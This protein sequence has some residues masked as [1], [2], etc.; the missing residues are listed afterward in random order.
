LD[1][2]P[3]P[4]V[5]G[6]ESGTVLTGGFNQILGYSGPSDP[7]AAL[8]YE[9]DFVTFLLVEGFT[10]A[11]AELQPDPKISG[12]DIDTNNDGVVDVTPWTAVLDGIGYTE[13]D[14]IGLGHLY[15]DQLGG[16][17]IG[18]EAAHGVGF[19]AD[20]VGRDPR[21]PEDWLMYDTSDGELDPGYV[22]LFYAN[23]GAGPGDSDAAHFDTSAGIAIE[24]PVYPTSTFLFATPGA[25]N[26]VPE[27]SSIVALIAAALSGCFAFGRRRCRK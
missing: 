16:L 4:G 22:G 1:N 7:P 8:E 27:P 23:D 12:A 25:A 15:A 5:Q 10:G 2:A 11:A 19:G 3:A 20:V 24:I 14:K 17:D 6:P 18:D 21:N 9:H 26:T 13:A